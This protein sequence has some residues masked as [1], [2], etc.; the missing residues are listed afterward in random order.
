M[1]T[2]FSCDN[3]PLQAMKSAEEELKADIL[4]KVLS[5]LSIQWPK[6]GSFR[7]KS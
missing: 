6:L 4:C 5:Q 2:L 7:I 1:E 3:L